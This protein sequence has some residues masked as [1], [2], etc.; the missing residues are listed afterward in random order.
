MSR[1]RPR[2]PG[3]SLRDRA[4]GRHHYDD[5]T[6]TTGGKRYLRSMV[7]QRGK[8]ELRRVNADAL[9]ERD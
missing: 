1:R 8:T 2:S 7:R 9:S 3:V 6:H 4:L 5:E